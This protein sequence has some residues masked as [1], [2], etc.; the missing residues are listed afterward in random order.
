MA[1]R[2]YPLVLSDPSADDIWALTVVLVCSAHYI[3]NRY[4]VAKLIEV[5][6][7]VNPRV[8]PQFQ[9]Y[10]DILTQH[11]L[12][13]DPLVPSLMK[14]YSGMMKRVIT[15]DFALATMLINNKHAY[16]VIFSV[17]SLLVVN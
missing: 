14:F 15:V 10:N 3:N 17:W 13:L 1:F 6:Y 8:Q 7:M 12:A 5:M 2:F 11:S 9:K 4:L 16:C